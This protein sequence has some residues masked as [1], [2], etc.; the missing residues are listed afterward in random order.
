MNDVVKNLYY[1]VG[2]SGQGC[3]F[4]TFPERDEHRKV[5]CGEI[6]GM[7]CSLVWQFEA[8]GLLE[9]PVM[10]WKDEPVK[11]ELN[12]KVCSEEHR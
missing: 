4:V 1:A 11:L 2:G 8:E 10:S 6:V 5:W 7:Y 12:L 3:I 9:L